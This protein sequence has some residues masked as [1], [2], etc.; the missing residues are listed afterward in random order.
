MK[1][2]QSFTIGI[3]QEKNRHSFNVVIGPLHVQSHNH[4]KHEKWLWY[5]Y[6][7]ASGILVQ[8]FRTV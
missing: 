5:N 6:F 3:I 7:E 2:I 8:D 4:V 1:A